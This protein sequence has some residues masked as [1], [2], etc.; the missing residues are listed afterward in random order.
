MINPRYKAFSVAASEG[1]LTK[2]AELLNYSPSGVS[3]L[4]TA[5]EKELGFSLFERSKKG[6]T[7]TS[8]GSAILPV[9]RELLSQEERLQQVIS[10]IHGLSVGVINI[11]AYSSIASHWL[12]GL[13]NQFCHQYPGI[14]INMMEGIHQKNEE[15]LNNRTVD[16][17]FFSYKKNMSYDWIPLA[18]DPMVA[19]L[20]KSHPRANDSSYPIKEVVKESFIMP[21]QGRDDDVIDLLKRHHIQPKIS[22]STLENFAALALIEEGLGMSI[23]NNL[24]TLN[25]QCDVVKLPVDPPSS[26]KLGIAIPSLEN[27]SPAVRRF[28]DFAKQ[29]LMQP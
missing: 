1:S 29:K 16:L 25:Y 8:N 5:L 7:I 4:I 14:K 17:A 2:A 20:P 9:I 21:A 6:L 10:E 15:W 26:I 18:D 24:I 23:M 22:F 28:I 12:P 27:A 13:I 3:Q 19:V 11:G